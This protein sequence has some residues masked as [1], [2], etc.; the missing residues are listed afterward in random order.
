[1]A[2]TAEDVALALQAVAGPTPEAP[3]AQPTAGRDFVAA[4]RNADAR[5]LRIA[6]CRDVAGIG[7]DAEVERVC[8]EA[9]F[10][11]ADAGATVEEIDLDLAYGRKAFLSLRG[12]WFVSML[13]PHLQHLES[14]GINVANNLRSGLG[15]SVEQLGAAEAARK[16]IRADF[17][18]LFA[19]YDH[20]LTPTMAVA[21]FPVVEN[22]PRTVGGREMETYVDWLAPTYVLSLT[23]LPIGSVPAG[24]DPDGMP[25]GLQVVGKPFGEEGVLA[26]MSVMQRVRPVGRPPLAA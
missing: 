24:L 2:R 11:L 23:G 9:A 1:M 21:P 14:F 12:L 17:A 20:L 25:C 18:A 3:L 22:Y 13:Y 19:R 16:R 10:A 5:G 6:Y 26:L 8:R 4:V 15:T 7:I